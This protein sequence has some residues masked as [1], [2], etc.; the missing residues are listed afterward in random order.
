VVYLQGAPPLLTR[1][2]LL[3]HLDGILSLFDLLAPF[4]GSHA[5][6]MPPFGDLGRATLITYIK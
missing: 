6:A 4:L 3:P 1:M 5:L 2:A